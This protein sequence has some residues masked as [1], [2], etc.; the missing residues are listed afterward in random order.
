LFGF[1][2]I[3]RCL[4]IGYIRLISLSSGKCKQFKKN[5]KKFQLPENTENKNETFLRVQKMYE[6]EH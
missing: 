4:I 3:A 5:A 2:L 6:R 1:G